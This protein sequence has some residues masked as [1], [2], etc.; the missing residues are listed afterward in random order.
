M[1]ERRTRAQSG[2]AFGSKTTHCSPRSIEASMKISSRRTLTY[3]QSESLVMTAAAVDADAAVVVAEV[4]DDVDVDRIGIED[5]VLLFVE[6]ALQSDDAAHDFV[7]GRLVHAALDVGARVD[8]DHVAARRD[9]VVLRSA[10]RL[11][12]YGSGISSQ[13]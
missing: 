12:G 3:F 10:P 13:G 7:G 4:A 2:S 11:T 9:R 5:V 1:I 6:H 8:A